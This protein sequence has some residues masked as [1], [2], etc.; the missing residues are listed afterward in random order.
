[1]ATNPPVPPDLLRHLPDEDRQALLA[2]A[3]KTEATLRAA[4]VQGTL[5]QEGS[6]GE[7]VRAVQSRLDQLGDQL[8][9]DGIFGPATKNAVREF[10]TT[11]NLASDGVV[12]PK[13]WGALDAAYEQVPATHITGSSYYPPMNYI[14]PDYALIGQSIRGRFELADAAYHPSGAPKGWTRLSDEQLNT[15]GLPSKDFHPKGTDFEASLFQSKD[16]QTVLAFRACLAGLG[17]KS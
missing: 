15:M 12:G 8:A 13:T 7:A 10:Q 11:H 3:A 2:E 14:N 6:Q 9:T 4:A 17:P 16:G 1:V 5:L